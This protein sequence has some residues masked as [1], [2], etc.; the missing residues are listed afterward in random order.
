MVK[1]RRPAQAPAGA[2]TSAT[3]N[4]EQLA[5]SVV[6]RPAA[7]VLLGVSDSMDARTHTQATL[8]EPAPLETATV[9]NRVLGICR[10][11]GIVSH[12]AII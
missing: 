12:L 10:C 7:R 4:F 2:A 11:T 6:P 9:L 3:N 1:C 5:E 8:N